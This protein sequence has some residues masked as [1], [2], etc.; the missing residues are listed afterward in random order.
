MDPININS[1][2]TAV[3]TGTV[4]P[5]VR[6]AKT[7]AADASLPAE[8]F[9]KGAMKS[10]PS[11]DLSAAARI[12]SRKDNGNTLKP[13]KSWSHK[14]NCTID[15]RVAVGNDGTVFGID[16]Y[17]KV[18]ALDSAGGKEI[19]ANE[20]NER[21]SDPVLG[22]NG[23]LY[24]GTNS[25]KVCAFDTKT[26]DKV[27]EVSTSKDAESS[28]T[29]DTPIVGPDGTVYVTSDKGR[30]IALDGATGDKKW[31]YSTEKHYGSFSEAALD[32][33]GNLIVG[34]YDGTIVALDSSKGSRIWEQK[35]DYE[36]GIAA[37]VVDSDGVVYAMCGA[38]PEDTVRNHP[39]G[40]TVLVAIGSQAKK[41]LMGKDKITPHILWKKEFET[42][43]KS[44]PAVGTFG[45]RTVVFAPTGDGMMQAVDGKTGEKL[46]SHA[47][48]RKNTRLTTFGSDRRTP[49]VD[50]MKNLIYVSSK[51]GA[52]VAMDPL[53]G[54]RVWQEDFTF[55]IDMD[56]LTYNDNPLSRPTVDG[57][58]NIYITELEGSLIKYGEHRL[59]KLEQELAET[60]ERDAPE[61]R[62]TEHDI[63]I[64]GVT[65]KKK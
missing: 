49:V 44:G 36:L 25:K 43:S 40:C 50:E 32:K 5:R 26:G 45:G 65:L 15:R 54:K 37:P 64:D 2:L 27:W 18:Y 53:N 51:D 39:N 46:W 14:A 23:L 12:L 48:E 22:E 63:D 29:P 61:I 8:S 9:S 52:L 3:S 4:T 11:A 55:K 56:P 59:A 7:E 19:W 31:I 1:S 38:R 17:G 13:E 30:V 47:S 33:N 57:R 60:P 42:A 62:E 20:M 16:C 10:V 21:F 34:C 6:K 28:Q 41:S 35:L 58:G 24:A